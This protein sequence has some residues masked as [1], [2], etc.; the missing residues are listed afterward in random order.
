VPAALS[1]IA[2]A[3]VA[4]PLLSVT[5]CNFSFSS[6]GG[7]DYDKLQTTI[8][9]KLKSGYPELIPDAPPVT[10]DRPAAPKPGDKFACTADVGG[11]PVRFEVS[12]TDDQ[13]NVNYNDLDYLYDMP[14]TAQGLDTQIESQM[15]FPV[16]VDCGSGLKS[17]AKG[18]TFTCE[19]TDENGD[20]KTVEVTATE[21]NNVD[22][23][24]VD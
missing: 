8:S 22:W 3:V 17:V 13:G 1:R 7:L 9:D 16:T 4:I 2:S 23:K 12:V 11:Q 5:G 15:G 19:A 21:M 20:S 18:D 24:L 6:G 10:C 14:R